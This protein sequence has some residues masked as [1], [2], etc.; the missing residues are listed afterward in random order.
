M[1]APLSGRT[2]PG[3]EGIGK[4]GAAGPR[5]VAVGAD[6]DGPRGGDGTEDGQLPGLGRGLGANQTDA[7]GPA[8]QVD[9]AGL[10]EAEEDGAGRVK[11]GED[12]LDAVGGDQ[13]E[14]GP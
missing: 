13:V 5:D 2:E 9:G 12:P 1:Q 11:Q 3:S 8:G 10:P 14:V 6:E 4:V 7:V